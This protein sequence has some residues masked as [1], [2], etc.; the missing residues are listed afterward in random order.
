[1]AKYCEACKQ[2]YPTELPAC[3]HCGAAAVISEGSRERGGKPTQLGSK[4]PTEM[5]P[6]VS[7]AK[8]H[9]TS[10]TDIARTGKATKLAGHSPSPT[11]IAK[12]D[13]LADITGKAPGEIDED[14]AAA[15]LLDEP[16]P[17]AESSAVDLG[18][19]PVR[20]PSP[21]DSGGSHVRVREESSDVE[22]G[23]SPAATAEPSSAT[24]DSGKPSSAHPSSDEIDLGPSSAEVDL[25][26]L[27]AGVAGD[28]NSGVQVEEEAVV[29]EAASP[30]EDAVAI[31]DEE[32]VS[33][34][35]PK[36][37]AARRPL[38]IPW[39]G[40]G[41]AGAVLGSA[42]SIG[43][44]W[45][46]GLLGGSSSATTG[47]MPAG[48]A[49]GQRLVPSAAAPAGAAE[50][51]PESAKIDEAIKQARGQQ[52]A[53][54][55]KMLAEGRSTFEQRLATKGPAT[56][57]A[58][59]ENFLHSAEELDRYWT[60]C[61]RLQASGHDLAKQAPDAAITALA[62]ERKASA[63]KIETASK[64]LAAQTAA[65]K[66]VAERAGVKSEK[67]TAEEVQKAIAGINKAKKDADE[68]LAT[69]KDD[70][71][72]AVKEAADTKKEADEK[73]ATQQKAV[74]ELTAARDSATRTLSEAIKKLEAAKMLP[75]KAG[76]ADFVKALDRTIEVAQAKDPGGR[77][78]ELQ[79]EVKELRARLVQQRSPREMLDIW[80]GLLDEGG[81]QDVSKQV[82]TDLDRVVAD[83]EATGE[84]KAKARFIQGLL[85]RSEGKFGEAR[86]ALEESL[87]ES[88]KDAAWREQARKAVQGL[89]DPN[90]YYV[91]RAEQLQ[92]AGQPQAAL[93]IVETGLKVFP[94]DE[95]LV[96][97]RRQAR[98]DLA[99]SQA[100]SKDADP[101][102][103][104]RHFANGLRHY[105]ARR[106]ADAEKEFLEATRKH[107][108]DARYLYFLGLSRLQQ[109]GK[110]DDALEDFRLGA[111]LE[112][113]S[114]PPRLVVNESLERIQGPERQTL[115]RA[116]P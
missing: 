85:L 115:N 41:V 72:K 27:E 81:R 45:I 97:L 66:A 50:A 43:I 108:Q 22:L 98:A 42:A 6:A 99:R 96:A 92:A 2:E 64:N 103:A 58:A 87:K 18:S 104:E 30:E 63:E 33:E 68:Q 59:E 83:K 10:E 51:L 57:D 17:R 28:S 4:S 73:L 74:G 46:G 39:I 48:P 25:D 11:M 69:V 53:A 84:Q 78:A 67:P 113:E 55:R 107:N 89:S 90:A 21:S 31:A 116:R 13:Q 91:P 20:P 38:P 3:P 100:K 109:S 14:A 102:E 19:R 93:E 86:S 7:S 60:A 112:S 16:S 70:L 101:A 111:M 34:A 5:M 26:A 24:S 54:A 75:P 52:Y 88:G 9:D 47:T 105:Y 76:A 29:E 1:M 114:K 56:K 80:L 94:K 12:Q 77:L 106:Y 23:A 71:A 8:P 36:K 110:R 82:K 40:G 61:E 37:R 62:T 44:L 15:A 49:M 35:A 79:I 65:L 95:R 32:P